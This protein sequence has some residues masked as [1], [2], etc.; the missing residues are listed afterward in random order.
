[1]KALASKVPHKSE[2][3][4]HDIYWLCMNK[5]LIKYKLATVSELIKPFNFDGYEFTSY[6]T[7]WWESDGW[8]ASKEIDAENAGKARYE[9]MKGLFPLVPELSVI[10]QC[11]FRYI[12]NTY[13]IYKLTNNP[14]KKIYIYFV[15]EVPP[16]GLHFDE[17]EIVNLMKIHNI[18][19]KH[20]LFFVADAANGGSFYTDLSMLLIGV[21]GLAGEIE[22]KGTKKTNQVVLKEILGDEL[23]TKLYPYG[24]GLRNL[25]FHG[26]I[27]NHSEFDGLV[28][29]VYSRILTY[30]KTKYDISLEENVVHPQRSFRGNFE[31]AMALEAFKGDPILDLKLIHEAF[32]DRQNRHDIF[33]YTDGL[34]DY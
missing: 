31:Q 9:F 17:N 14:E 30:L 8:V 23:F 22:S 2:N 18:P 21:E 29:I 33:T 10:S 6:N 4:R 26:K 16:V 13:F 5:Y 25:L 15:R 3:A 27:K 11:A 1:M 19:N 34:Q 32:D 12:A 20:G 7:E 24:E 28:E